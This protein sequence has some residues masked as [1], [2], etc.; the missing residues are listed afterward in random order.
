MAQKMAEEHSQYGIQS[1]T[2]TRPSVFQLSVPALLEN[3]V[4]QLISPSPERRGGSA[5]SVRGELERIQR[6]PGA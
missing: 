4:L 1:T 2:P 5:K 6:F 3:F